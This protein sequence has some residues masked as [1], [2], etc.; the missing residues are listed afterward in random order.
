MGLQ[1]VATKQDVP[2]MVSVP[3]SLEFWGTGRPPHWASFD[4]QTGNK[5]SPQGTFRELVLTPAELI[6]ICP[7]GCAGGPFG[8]G[9]PLKPEK[10]KI[11]NAF[12]APYLKARPDLPPATPSLRV[13][14]RR[15]FEQQK[16]RQQAKLHLTGEPSQPR[17]R[18]GL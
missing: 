10:Q 4:S 9:F 6:L 13:A 15:L 12:G 2:P 5:G 18:N 8:G 7:N 1:K 14:P 11:K 3:R 16:Q 17:P